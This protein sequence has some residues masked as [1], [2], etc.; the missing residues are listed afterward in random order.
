[1]RLCCF[2]LHCPFYRYPIFKAMSD[3]FNCDFYFNDYV[4]N[5]PKSFDVRTLPGF[6]SFL[7]GYNLNFRGYI[8]NSGFRQILKQHYTHFLLSGDPSYILNWLIVI[9]AKLTNKRVYLWCHGQKS[10]V[11]RRV[12]RLYCKLFYSHVDGI[13]VYGEHVIPNMVD[14]GCRP[15]IIHPIHN[16]LD[17]DVQNAIYSCIKESEIYHVHYGNDNPVVIYIGRIQKRKKVDQLIEA[18]DILRNEGILVNLVIVGDPMDDYSIPSLVEDKK[19]EKQVWFYGPSYNEDIN[20]E[21]IYNA[22]VCVSPGNVGLTCIHALSYGT[23]VVSNN[24]FNTQ[25]PE[26]EAIEVGVTGSFFIENDINDIANHIK[27]WI[28][29]SCGARDAI[30]MAARRKILEEWSIDYQIKTFSTV[31]NDN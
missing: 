22:D 19:L 1:M 27:K 4:P 28:G 8:W 26:Y 2:F 23:P 6:E 25:M 21:L 10:P 14:I 11:K 13:F 9:Y 3:I 30:R 7:K 20:A 24:N 29:L 15:E 31:I 18:I 5:A 12:T 16:S 17:T